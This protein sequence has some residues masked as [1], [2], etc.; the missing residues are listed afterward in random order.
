MVINII[1]GAG[2]SGNPD[3]LAAFNRAAAEWTTQI[4]TNIIVNINADLADLGGGGIIGATS[5]NLLQGG[6]DVVRDAMAA[7]SAA[8]PSLAILNS[9][10]TAAQFS[11]YVP[12]GGALLNAMW[13]TSANAHALGF[14]GDFGPD[15]DITFNSQFA[16]A[17][18]RANLNNS[19]MD[20]QTV[21]AHEIGHALGF[22]SSVDYFDLGYSPVA[23]TTLDMF[24]FPANQVPTTASE[25]TNLPRAMAPGQAAVTSDT[26]NS[27]AM[28]TGTYQGDGRQ[29]SHWKDDDLTGNLIGIMDPT[30]NFGTIEAVSASDL[31]AME[32][33]G[34]S[35]AVP[36][37]STMG[38]ACGA[39]LIGI[40]ARRLRRKSSSA[41]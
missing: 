22:L 3:A 10:P 12:S 18:D 41:A 34:Y 7:H 17:Y 14:T 26:V 38:Q 5:S 20:F 33:I 16:F 40:L 4:S 39:L 19:N 24:R 32:L 13:L 8:S 35:V 1:P 27:Y 28:S 2:L 25:F 36:E 9:L 6:F 29:A 31:R 23:V 15:A 11:A 37:L 21:A 30:L